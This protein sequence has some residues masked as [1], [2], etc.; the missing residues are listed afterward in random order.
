MIFLPSSY[1]AGSLR[2]WR[3]RAPCTR[4]STQ[5]DACTDRSISVLSRWP[6]RRRERAQW[7]ISR[8][9][10]GSSFP[11]TVPVLT[12]KFLRPGQPLRPGQT[13]PP[14]STSSARSE[15]SQRQM[16]VLWE[17]RGRPPA[18]SPRESSLQWSGIFFRYFLL[19]LPLALPWCGSTAES[20]R[21]GRPCPA[22]EWAAGAVCGSACL[23]LR[24]IEHLHPSVVNGPSSFP[25][26]LASAYLSPAVLDQP[27]HHADWC[28]PH[29]FSCSPCY[30]NLSRTPQIFPSIQD[31][32][33]NSST[34]WCCGNRDTVAAPFRGGAENTCS[35]KK[36]ESSRFLHFPLQWRDS[37]TEELGGKI[38]KFFGFTQLLW[39]FSLKMKNGF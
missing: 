35:P 36:A 7:P 31:E 18:I 21:G 22:G 9:A 12:L 25:A 38:S 16:A 15:N 4:S 2:C 11:Q 20:L 28:S 19:L 37:G 33:C 27:I 34:R 39:D 32:G 30:P 24:M 8:A 5:P 23:F 14:S 6:W 3:K 1:L 10:I 26:S 29:Q 13:G 17:A